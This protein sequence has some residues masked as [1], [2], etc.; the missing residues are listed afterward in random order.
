MSETAQTKTV[1]DTTPTIET[2]R[3]ATA[4]FTR[5]IKEGAN[6]PLFIGQT[7][8]NALR[9]LGYNDTTSAVCEFVD[10][11]VQWGAKEVRVYFNES[12]RKGNKR[13][14]ILIADDAAGMAPNVL[15]AAT[16]FGGSMCFDNRN[17]SPDGRSRWSSSIATTSCC[18]RCCSTS[19]R[20]ISTMCRSSAGGSRRQRFE[21][22]RALVIGARAASR[23]RRHGLQSR[24]DALVPRRA[25]PGIAILARCQLVRRDT[26]A[27]SL[28]A[29][30]MVDAES[31]RK[32][33]VTGNHRVVHG[34]RHDDAGPLRRQAGPSTVRQADPERGTRRDAKRAVGI[35]LAPP[36]IAHDRV[37][38]ER[39]PLAR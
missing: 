14:D 36:R 22:G 11:S 15:R 4:V 5:I 39:P 6:V 20:E 21:A 17:G 23:H 38:G 25:D 24:R 12:G 10:N 30:G 19:A 27:H 7:L 28:L 2:P 16:A 32:R 8:V 34:D 35:R 26:G 31:V 9:D 18:D 33:Q 3:G 37:R 1:E 13:L 29:L